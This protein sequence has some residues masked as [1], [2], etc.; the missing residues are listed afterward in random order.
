MAARA[1]WFEDEEAP[2]EG[3]GDAAAAPAEGGAEGAETET[4]AE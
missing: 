1:H 3:E 2:A 4:P